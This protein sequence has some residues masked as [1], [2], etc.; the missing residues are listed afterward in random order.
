VTQKPRVNRKQK[1]GLESSAT[2]ARLLQAAE[3]LMLEEGYMA[4]TSRRVGN[5]AGVRPQLVHYYF[6]TMDD[7]FIA[8]F[9]HRSDQSWQ[10]AMDALQSDE[11]LRAIW[12]KG[13]DSR[14]ITLTLEFIA[15][16]NH[17]KA[18]RAELAHSGEQFR[19]LQHA[20]VERYLAQRGI[21]SA[22]PARVMSFILTSIGLLL[23]MESQIG[24]SYSH[25]EVEAFIEAALKRFEATGRIEAG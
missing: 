19:Q 4:V 23:V 24:V 10:G 1:V 18:I 21:E 22:I 8:L 6:P 3:Q 17:R 9:R 20:A 2:R 5:K 16:A 11:P 15:L 12:E 25:E 7:L 13:K 14:D